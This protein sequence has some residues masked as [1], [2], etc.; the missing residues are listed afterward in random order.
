MGAILTSRRH[1]H[2]GKVIVEVLLDPAE[3]RQLGGE[4]DNIYLF[5]ERA[6]AIP[7]RVSLRGRN[8]ATKYFLI[9][10]Q[11]RRKLSISG[12]VSCQRF[13]HDC[14][15]VFIYVVDPCKSQHRVSE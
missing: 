2:T 5:T 13:D 6:A 15:S 10:R 3:Y 12:G 8:E 1:E 7:S 9:P 4:M 11:L 14:R